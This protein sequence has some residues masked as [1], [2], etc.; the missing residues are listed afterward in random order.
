MDKR[1]FEQAFNAVF[2][3]QSAFTDFCDFIIEKEIET[4]EIGGRKVFRTSTNERLKAYL[5]FID[6]VIL[7]HL[8][9]DEDVVH[10]FIKGK[11]ALTAVQSHANSKY[12]FLTDIKDFF[13]SINSSDVKRVLERDVERIPIIDLGNYIDHVV[14]ITTVGGSIPVGFSTS[15]RLSNA[16]LYDFDQA[17]KL[18]C[19]ERNLIYTRYVDDIIISGNSYDQLSSLKH[20]VQDLLVRHG[21]PNLK[22]KESKTHITKLGNKVKI[23]GLVVLPNGHITIDGKY[24]KRIELLLHFYSTDKDKYEDYLNKEFG[25]SEH[26]LFGLLHYARSVDPHYLEKIQRKYGFFSLKT[27]M[28]DKWNDQ[29]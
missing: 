14:K 24:K 15:P 3:D 18:F 4:F 27:L 2:H 11:S 1:T 25:G 28:E 29:R 26:S 8:F 20:I 9:K 16:Y 10:S 23:L 6:R 21:S 7:R 17:L 12:F 22:L 19:Q 5:R 13:P